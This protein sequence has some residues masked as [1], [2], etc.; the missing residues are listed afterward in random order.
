MLMKNIAIAFSGVFRYDRFP[1]PFY[2][3]DKPSKK[4]RKKKNNPRACGRPFI[5]YFISA[6]TVRENFPRVIT[7]VLIFST[8]SSHIYFFLYAYPQ[9][10][11]DTFLKCISLGGKEKRT[12]FPVKLRSR[13]S[14]S[15]HTFILFI[16]AVDVRARASPPFHRGK[17]QVIYRQ[18][19]KKEE[20]NK[21]AERRN[22]QFSG[23]SGYLGNSA[24]RRVVIRLDKRV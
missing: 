11:P 18:L 20:N 3:R 4:K 1:I 7:C 8:I 6:G 19:I 10:P 17:R 23:N 2:Q 15:F 9:I 16:D 22:F 24:G 5:R 12:T 21:G 14:C 13:N